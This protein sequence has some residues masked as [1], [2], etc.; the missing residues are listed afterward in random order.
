LDNSRNCLP[1][2]ITH[3]QSLPRLEHTQF[4]LWMRK[5]VRMTPHFCASWQA[6]VR[7]NITPSMPIKKTQLSHVFEGFFLWKFFS[8]KHPEAFEKTVFLIPENLPLNKKRKYKARRIFARNNHIFMTWLCSE[9]QGVPHTKATEKSKDFL[10]IYST[11]YLG[12]WFYLD[13]IFFLVFRP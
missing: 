13:K 3:V 2:Q 6:D 5:R 9:F 12:K 4:S 7:Y 1:R 8:S 10:S 11:L